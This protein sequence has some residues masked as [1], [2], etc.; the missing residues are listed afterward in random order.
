M[1][2]AESLVS[3]VGWPTSRSE[4]VFSGLD[5]ALTKQ[6]SNILE[7]SLVYT[8]SFRENV[9]FSPFSLGKRDVFDEDEVLLLRRPGLR[10]KD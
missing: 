9:L 8:P 5:L 6:T 7:G 10:S 2:N 1:L 3:Y 4:H